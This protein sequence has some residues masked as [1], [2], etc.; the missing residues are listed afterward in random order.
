MLSQL[1]RTLRGNLVVTKLLTTNMPSTDLVILSRK[2]YQE[3]TNWILKKK[4]NWIKFYRWTF[5]NFEHNTRNLYIY[6]LHVKVFVHLR[7]RDVYL[8]VVHHFSLF[9]TGKL[10][11]HFS[12]WMLASKT[13]TLL[14]WVRY[15]IQVWFLHSTS[16][17]R[18]AIKPR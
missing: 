2:R 13:E 12:M 17:T 15:I 11:C 14:V 9:W 1:F 5:S 18:V 16:A 6:K 7:L 8:N 10:V 3:K 4:I